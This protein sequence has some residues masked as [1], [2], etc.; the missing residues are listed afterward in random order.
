M[1]EVTSGIMVRLKHVRE[2]KMCMKGMRIWFN[3][4]GL[5]LSEFRSHG[6]PVEVIEATGDQMALNVAKLARQDHG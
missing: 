1:T 5:P 4:H 6:L 2:A 3:H